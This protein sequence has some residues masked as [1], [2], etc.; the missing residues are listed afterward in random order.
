MLTLSQVQALYKK[1]VAEE[2][3]ISD[4]EGHERFGPMLMAW[5]AS[6][7]SQ[8]SNDFSALATLLLQGKFE[9]NPMLSLMK[10]QEGAREHFGKLI[11]EIRELAAELDFPEAKLVYNKSAVRK[12]IDQYDEAHPVEDAQA[13][14]PDSDD[15]E[16]LMAAAKNLVGGN[17]RRF[18]KIRYW[19]G[20]NRSDQ[21][22]TGP[23]NGHTAEP[24]AP[25]ADKL[26]DLL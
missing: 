9:T 5:R 13:V 24:A 18:A 25:K 12:M 26:A 15:L 10:E 7:D 4:V 11:S 22:G 20:M 6:L 16:A 1:L 8:G 14:L 21:D 23:L 2:A 3:T 17:Q 19:L